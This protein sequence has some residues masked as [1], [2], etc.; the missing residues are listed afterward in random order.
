MVT[1]PNPRARPR[2]RQQQQLP[3]KQSLVTAPQVRSSPRLLSTAKALDILPFPSSPLQ[4]A[5]RWSQKSRDALTPAALPQALSVPGHRDGGCSAVGSLPALCAGHPSSAHP[6]CCLMDHHQQQ[7]PLSASSWPAILPQPG[8]AFPT[9]KELRV[10]HKAE[11]PP[12]ARWWHQ[13]PM[14]TAVGAPTDPLPK[15][16]GQTLQTKS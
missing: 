3:R 15:A 8:R 9:T 5:G 6:P 7:L 12:C 2:A 11:L 10:I 14:S 4:S 1:N 13:P 16:A